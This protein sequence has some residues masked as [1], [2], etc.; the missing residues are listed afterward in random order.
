MLRHKASNQK[1]VT[2]MTTYF[3]KFLFRAAL[4]AYESSW[5]RGQIGAVAANHSHSDKGSQLHL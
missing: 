4:A 3:L 5:A 1:G 2:I